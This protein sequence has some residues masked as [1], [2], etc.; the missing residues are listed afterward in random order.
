VASTTGWALVLPC[1]CHTHPTHERE[2]QERDGE[3]YL[4]LHHNINRQNLIEARDKN[5]NKMISFCPITT[6][7]MQK[8]H[9]TKQDISHNIHELLL[10]HHKSKCCNATEK[11]PVCNI[12]MFQSQQ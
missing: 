4:S 5:N 8:I 3:K 6:S 7:F 1:A 2:R 10:Q 12:K 9:E 11:D